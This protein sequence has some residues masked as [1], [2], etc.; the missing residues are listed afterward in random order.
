A[1]SRRGQARAACPRRVAVE[2]GGGGAG[3]RMGRRGRPRGG[4]AGRGVW[5]RAWARAWVAGVSPE[6]RVIGRF[7]RL[8]PAAPCGGASGY[9]SRSRLVRPTASRGGA[10]YGVGR[11]PSAS[12]HA[13]RQALGIEPLWGRAVWGGAR[14]GVRPRWWPSWA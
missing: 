8:S 9:R 7:G 3:R 2:T 10:Q 4:R 1:L 12:H 6:R 13:F 11:A 14:A 5:E